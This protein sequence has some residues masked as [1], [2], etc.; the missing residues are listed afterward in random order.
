MR[1]RGRVVEGNSLENCRGFTSLVSSNL[2]AS[3]KKIL[4]HPI[5]TIR[6]CRS[7]LAGNIH[8]APLFASAPSHICY[9]VTVGADRPGFL[10]A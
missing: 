2:T 10:L 3:A 4:I 5:D 8:M 9:I 7:W 6:C 1:K